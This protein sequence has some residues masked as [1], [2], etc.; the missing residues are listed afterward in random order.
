MR[1]PE[2][3]GNLLRRTKASSPRRT[4][5]SGSSSGSAAA[6]QNTHSSP[7]SA[8]WTYSSRHG[9]QSCFIAAE[10]TSGLEPALPA[11][12][13]EHADDGRGH[14]ADRGEEGVPAVE[15]GE[16][17]VHAEEPGDERQRRQHDE[18]DREDVEDVVLLVRDERLVRALE[19]LD[20][21]L[22][23]VEQVPDPLA[24]VDDVV[25]VEL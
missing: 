2:L 10:A 7:S 5:S 13:G 15:A 11:E 20:D 21:L 25:E 19:R 9:A 23:V 4:T 17:D 8:C 6:R 1:C 16:M 12:E 22:V 3:Y 18:E 14:E 24:R